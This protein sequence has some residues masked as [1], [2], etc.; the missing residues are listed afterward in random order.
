MDNIDRY[1]IVLY[2]IEDIQTIFKLGRT[3]AYELMSSDGFPSFKLN[4]RIYV[5]K[6]RLQEWINKRAGKEYCF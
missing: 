4:S 5:E 3:K 1:D 2:T 6:S